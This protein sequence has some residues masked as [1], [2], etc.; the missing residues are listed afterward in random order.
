MYIII[1]NC[2]HLLNKKHNEISILKKFSYMLRQKQFAVR[3]TV[4]LGMT[5][6][7]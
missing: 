7:T 3:R 4:L 6:V 1:Y 5:H 2:I